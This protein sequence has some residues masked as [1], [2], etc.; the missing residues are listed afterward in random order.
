[1]KEHLRTLLQTS[2]SPVAARNLVREY[3]QTLIR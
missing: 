1:M 3:F 2:F